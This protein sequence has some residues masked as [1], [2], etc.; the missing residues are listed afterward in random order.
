MN[1]TEITLSITS[2]RNE[3]AIGVVKR[4]GVVVIRR[5]AHLEHLDP[6]LYSPYPWVVTSPGQLPSVEQFATYY[7]A[8]GRVIELV[9]A[10]YE[11]LISADHAREA[12]AQLVKF[13]EEIL[14]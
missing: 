8:L 11:R 5:S 3:G 12:E 4:D 9:T 14:R 13:V 10:E 6:G 7:G 2:R 1:V